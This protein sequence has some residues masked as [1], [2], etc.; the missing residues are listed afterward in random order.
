[1]A[2]PVFLVAAERSGTTLLRLML[3]GHPQISWPCEFDFAVDWPERTAGEWPDVAEFRKALADNRQAQQARIALDP[4]LDFP[5]LVLSFYSQLRARTVKPIVGVT[6]HRHYDRL[7][8]LWPAAQFIH[9]VRD[10]RD[11]A[12]SHVEMGWAG[13]VWVAAPVW[14][15]AETSWRSLRAGLPQQR[16]LE[17]RY[18]TL[19]R[20]P[21]LELGRVCA[22]LGTSYAPEMLD[23]PSRSTY[24][25]LDPRLTERWRRLL[26]RRDLALLERQIG[27]DLAAAG[28]PPAGVPPAWIPKPR[29]LALRLGDRVGRARFRA[30]RYGVALWLE[31]QLTRRLGSSAARRG[32]LERMR[33]IDIDHLK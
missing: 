29:Q 5:D 10:G 4:A 11:V 16:C 25:P 20:A 9:L 19:V 32:V 24:G 7:L 22:F 6:A 30:K 8:R 14:R 18:E 12:R 2:N 17:V 3:D 1:V 15:E 23:Y 33:R 27:D 26:S 31:H 13:N 28:Y 21:E